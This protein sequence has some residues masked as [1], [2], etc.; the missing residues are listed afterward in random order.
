MRDERDLILTALSLAQTGKDLFDNSFP[1]VFSRISPQAPLLG[2]YWTVPIISLFHI[3]SP[4]VVK[5]LY[6][7]PTLFFPLLVFELIYVITKEKKVSFLAAFVVSFSPWYFHISRLAIE[8]H[9]AYFFCL[10]GLIFYTSKKKVLG[11]VFLLISYFSYFGIRPFL[12]FAIPY[13]ELSSYFLAVKKNWKTIVLSISIFLILFTSVFV[14]SSQIEKNT[15]RSS[16]EI[17]LL[18]NKKL[19][20]ET[21]FLRE[22][23]DAPFFMRGLIDNKVSLISKTIFDTF[24]K[25]LDFSYLFSTGDYVGIYA[26]QITGQFF[27]FMFIFLVLG[28]CFL[29]KK[30]K[31][32]YF[33][34]AGLS[35]MGLIS[36]LINSYSLT[37]SIRS[38]FSL[39][40]IGFI[41]ALGI[42]Y[43]YEFF[44][45]K[46]RL[47]Y[48]STLACVYIFFSLI[49]FYK[50]LFQIY[51]TTNNAFNE[52][53]RYSSDFM[54]KNNIKTIIA[55]R[56][57]SYYLSYL[58]TL[59]SLSP[60]ILIKTQNELKKLDGYNLENHQ[61]F[62][63]NGQQINY[64][65]IEAVPSSTL[66]EES[67]LS[68]DSKLL[69]SLNKSKKIVEL[70]STE[71]TNN[72]DSTF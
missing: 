5:I 26:N 14:L 46:W 25:G 38:I 40:G 60:S 50:Y 9:L 59:P 22:I 18:N 23:S 52:Q 70:L 19:T 10:L 27:P 2:M 56:I 35:L 66:I 68:S 65:S 72:L 63:C 13:F 24:F 11:L 29:A 51:K 34:I 1:L 39:I 69:L 67:C 62:M 44:G 17:I 64:K 49:F 20:L 71:Y 41:C 3:T 55:P 28:I 57:H 48:V 45:K 15:T 4:F 36:S 31:R 30:K 8:A 7:L 47:I 33:M 53:E 61:F 16:N 32:E 42:V 58:T 37:F 43:L 21:N 54:R 6:L 12:L